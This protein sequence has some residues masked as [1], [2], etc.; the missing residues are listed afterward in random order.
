MLEEYVDKADKISSKLRQNQLEH[1][2]LTNKLLRQTQDT[3]RSNEDLR[4]S[5]EQSRHEI[6]A[7]KQVLE[8]CQA[9]LAQTKADLVD[10]KSELSTCKAVYTAAERDLRSQAEK[11]R[12]LEQSLSLK[13]QRTASETGNVPCVSN[14]D[15]LD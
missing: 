15:T 10:C 13:R 5:L 14:I 3:K 12:A 1:E 8:C 7:Q 4:K 11:I 6:A 9:E 2:D